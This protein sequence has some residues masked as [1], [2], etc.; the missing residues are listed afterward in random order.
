MDVDHAL[1]TIGSL[2]RYQKIGVVLMSLAF[3]GSIVLP[4]MSLIFMAVEP[5]WRC[6][7]GSVACNHTGVFAP[8]DDLYDYRCTLKRS[9]WEF[10]SE[11]STITTE[12]SLCF[13]FIVATM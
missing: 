4:N 5:P 10:H 2:G 1:E 7:P 6:S 8:G 12:V 3:L 11:Y 9:D 13:T